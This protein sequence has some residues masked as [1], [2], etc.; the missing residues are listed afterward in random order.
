MRLASRVRNVP[1]Y[2]NDNYGFATLLGLSQAVY[3]DHVC[4][5]GPTLLP[6]S[7]YTK[8]SFLANIVIGSSGWLASSLIHTRLA[9][10]MGG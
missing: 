8:G 6:L 9:C 10:P 7:R 5:E 1:S 4:M 2:R 3:T